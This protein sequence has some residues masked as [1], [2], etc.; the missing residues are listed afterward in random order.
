MK[1]E[2]LAVLVT[3][4]NRPEKLE[5]V[6]R[7]LSDIPGLRLYFACDGPRTESERPLVDR[8]RAIA[9]SYI[10]EPSRL[11]LLDHHLGCYRAMFEAIS[12]FFSLETEGI[13]NE[14]DVLIDK[15]FIDCAR[16]LLPA[17]RNDPQFYHINSFIVPEAV[18][19]KHPFFVGTYANSWGWATWRDR[20]EKF[21]HQM[22]LDQPNWKAIRDSAGSLKLA[23]FFAFAFILT[24]QGKINSWHF[25]WTYSIWINHGLTLTPRLRLS[26][27]FGIDSTATHCSKEF[28]LIGAR[29]SLP[30]VSECE[31]LAFDS[32]VRERDQLILLSY[33][34]PSPWRKIS[35]MFISIMAPVSVFRFIR[36]RFR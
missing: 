15:S 22:V 10:S 5:R 23:L 20:W 17:L 30:T 24:R 32:R 25:R 19:S 12:W 9:K 2:Y 35:R 26:E 21:S 4:F 34:L 6:F 3:A 13:I 1:Q 36:R 16:V 8:C 14:D 28:H 31:L 29:H 18:D 7:H 33:S 27:N 11:R